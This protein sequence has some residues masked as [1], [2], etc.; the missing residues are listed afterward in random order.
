MRAPYPLVALAALLSLAEAGCTSTVAPGACGP[1]PDENACPTRRG[2]TCADRTCSALYACTTSGWQFVEACPNAVGGAAGA[3]GVAGA[4]GVAGAAGG[5]GVAG[6]AGGAC[7]GTPSTPPSEPPCEPLQEPDCDEGIALACPES[8]CL[9][10]C[11]V[12]L[13]CESGVWDD[14]IAAYCDAETGEL[15][16][17]PRP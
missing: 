7:S 8:A 2:G 13:R 9:T 4:S 15:V 1:L 11:T 14:D 5:A 16:S 6:A 17:N 10:G 12:F 3:A